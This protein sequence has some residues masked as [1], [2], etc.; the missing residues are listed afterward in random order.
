MKK[1]FSIY[2]IIWLLG[3]VVFNIIAFISP[4][5]IDGVSK[6]DG[7]F[8]IGYI[9]I[10]V[11]YLVQLTCGIITFKSE[12]TKE[13][14]YNIPLIY[15]SYAALILMSVVGI[16]CMNV[17]VIPNWIA[18][19]VCVVTLLF[20]VIAIIKARAAA[21]TVSEID[22]DTRKKTRF[23]KRLTLEAENLVSVARSDELRNEAKRVYEAFRYSDPMSNVSLSELESRIEKQFNSFADAVEEDDYELAKETAIFLVGMVDERN[24]KCKLLKF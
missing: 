14:F 4:N 22:Y 2:T 16:V 1:G 21:N 12:N 15:I 11:A 5:E 7:A 17:S 20:N 13:L 23:I 10:T 3:I 24:Q 9:F 19:I 18:I 8:W 6:F